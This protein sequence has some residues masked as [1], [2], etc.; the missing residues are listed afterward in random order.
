MLTTFN[1]PFGRYRWRRLPFGICSAPEVFQRR[2]HELIEGLHGVEVV[3]DDFVV[4][5]FGDD[6]RAAT[7][8]HDAN[9]WAFM[10]RC[11]DRGVHLNSAKL[12]LRK[13]RVAFVGHVA[14]DKGLCVDPDKVKAVVNMPSPT[15]MTGVQRLLGMVLYLTKFVPHLSDIAKPLRDLTLKGSD[16]IWEGPQQ[17]AFEAIKKCVSCTPVLKYYNQDDEVTLQCDAS[18]SGLGVA[19]LQNGQPVAYASRALTPAE[20]RYAQIEKELLAIVFACT[21]F[22]LYIFGRHKVTIESDHKP[23]EV[24]VRKPLHKAPA[25]LQRMLLVLQRYNL[26]V[27]YKQGASMYLA[28]TLSRAHLAGTEQCVVAA[29]METVDHKEFLPIS[30]QRWQQIHNAAENDTTMGLLRKVIHTGWPDSKSD[31]PEAV[32]AY[33]VARQH[34]F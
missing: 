23:L 24:I 5:G 22:D 6:F 10:Q 32:L 26:D 1:T 9:L 4:I 15:D 30:S 16:W 27:T 14:T 19:F 7:A 34:G 31:V 25:R 8:D 21:H 28:D 13:D 11:V 29:L 12:Q 33:F 17:R 3:A 18:Q 2:M 20:A